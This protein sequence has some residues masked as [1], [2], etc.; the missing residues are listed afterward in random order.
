MNLLNSNIEKIDTRKERI[1]LIMFIINVGNK[2]INEDIH[3]F[4]L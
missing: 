2:Y 4:I 1:E 3:I